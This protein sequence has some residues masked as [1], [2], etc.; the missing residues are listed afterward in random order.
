M[1]NI[2]SKRK[3]PLVFFLF[4]LLLDNYCGRKTSIFNSFT[5]TH[6]RGVHLR[7]EET[8]LL[9]L[10]LVI[11]LSIKIKEGMKHSTLL[12]LAWLC[13]GYGISNGYSGLSIYAEV[14][15]YALDRRNFLHSF[16]V[17]CSAINSG[18]RC[19]GWNVLRSRSSCLC[20]WRVGLCLVMAWVCRNYFEHS[21]WRCGSGLYGWFMVFALCL[22]K[23]IGLVVCFWCYSLVFLSV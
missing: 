1:C 10:I 3:S 14:W 7:L 11:V 8:T 12:S 21:L 19:W 15:L 17:V 6:N 22:E 2:L 20:C 13:Y 5:W 18:C 4:L 16:S 9:S 23:A